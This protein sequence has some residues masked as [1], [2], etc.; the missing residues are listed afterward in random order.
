MRC[1][2]IRCWTEGGTAGALRCLRHAGLAPVHGIRQ[3]EYR[4]SDLL[5]VLACWSELHN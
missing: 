5:R 1:I 4:R 3:F 2:G